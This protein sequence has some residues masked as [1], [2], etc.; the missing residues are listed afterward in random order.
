VSKDGDITVD[1]SHTYTKAGSYTIVTRVTD[2]F[3]TSI[4]VS[5]TTTVT[6]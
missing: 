1:G 3:G 2:Q 6:N 4:S 5:S